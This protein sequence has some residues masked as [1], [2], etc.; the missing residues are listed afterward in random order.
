[1]PPDLPAKGHR[2]IGG[3]A[4]G[5]DQLIA[6]EIKGAVGGLAV[7]RVLPRAIVIVGQADAVRVLHDRDGIAVWRMRVCRPERRKDTHDEEQEAGE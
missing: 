2:R 3:D 6:V 5:K 4:A 1:M 7:I